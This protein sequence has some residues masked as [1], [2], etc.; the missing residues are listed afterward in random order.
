MKPTEK[1]GIDQVLASSQIQYVL[2]Y[3][4][5]FVFS[6]VSGQVNGW[7]TGLEQ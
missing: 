3:S 6:F 4:P 7:F 2:K 1:K 5:D